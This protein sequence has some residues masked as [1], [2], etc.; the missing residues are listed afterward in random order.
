MKK[1]GILAFGVVLSVCMAV[2]SA[3][4]EWIE[5]AQHEK[6]YVKADGV[7]N[8]RNHK[9]AVIQHGLA[10]N[11]E[12]Q[13]V[14]AAKKAFL[15]NGYTVI[16]FD[17]RHSLGEG[18]NDVE[19][20]SLTTFEEDLETVT[21]WAKTR[22]FYSEPFALSGH[23]LGGASVLQYAA[24]YPDRV[25]VLIPI[26]P[27]LSGQLWEKTC[28]KN[29]SPFCAEWQKNGSYEYTDP[30]NHKK[31]VISY[32][33]IDTAKGYDATTLAPAVKAKTL[34]IT[35]EEDLVV[36]ASDVQHF[37]PL[38]PNGQV[39]TIVDSGHNFDTLQNQTDLYTA[40]NAF[41]TSL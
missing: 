16:L 4:A 7:E 3:K 13:A 1:T 24:K 27:V 5:N 20:V 33:V 22:P 25:N 40:I 17:S 12:H 30:Q 15:D 21:A 41:L 19:K 23:S 14:Q 18:D 11:K 28:L 8:A 38:L 35:A 10:S 31:A 9:L 37:A 34:L 36:N 26:S 39:V 29:L 6:I 2:F 32:S